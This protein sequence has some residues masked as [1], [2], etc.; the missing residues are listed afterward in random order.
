MP[1]FYDFIQ[2]PLSGIK[3][4]HT[5]CSPP[6]PPRSLI[7][8][9][10]PPNPPT[11]PPRSRM[12]NMIAHPLSTTRYIESRSRVR[13]RINEEI[14]GDVWEGREKGR[15]REGYEVRERDGIFSFLGKDGYRIKGGEALWNYVCFNLPA[16][17]L[18][19]FLFF[20]RSSPYWR[21]VRWC[22]CQFFFSTP[23]YCILS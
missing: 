10:G 13:S 9:Q 12:G 16:P 15:G 22:E 5:Q 14:W 3:S 19:F 1:H 17:G 4:Y 2:D 23:H 20:F 6:P 7:P 8:D 21:C 11:P 18:A